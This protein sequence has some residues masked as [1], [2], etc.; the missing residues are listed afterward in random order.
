[1][2]S[3]FLLSLLPFALATSSPPAACT[4]NLYAVDGTGSFTNHVEYTFDSGSLPDGLSSSDYTVNDLDDPTEHATHNHAFSPAN[5]AFDSSY[6]TLTVKGP[7]PAGAAVS[8]AEVVTT[9]DTILYGSFRTTAILPTVPGAVVGFFSYVNPGGEQDMEFLTNLTAQSNDPYNTGLPGTPRTPPLQLTNHAADF[10]SSK[11][12]V[13]AGAATATSEE[14][15]YRLDW[16]P[17]L[18]RY[19]I[20]GEEVQRFEEL[21]PDVA[22]TLIWNSWAN[23]DVGF[24][25]GPPN[26]DV[27]TRIR[28]VEMYYNSTQTGGGC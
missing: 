7:T 2:T 12:A 13:A 16:A 8:S 23:G 10:A 9:D 17:G 20:D 28:K 18:S 6:L 24:T 1:M 19:F 3:I 11:H 22:S 26:E 25:T 27:V 14:H 4:N 5:V 15:E 21:V